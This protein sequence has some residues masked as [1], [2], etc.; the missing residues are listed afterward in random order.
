[1]CTNDP[2]ISRDKIKLWRQIRN[3]KGRAG[4]DRPDAKRICTKI[5][6]IEGN[7]CLEKRHRPVAFVLHA[8][9]S[10]VDV[11]KK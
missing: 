11:L 1:M 9:T 10:S 5:A 4:D 2:K 8:C 3:R 7:T 6:R